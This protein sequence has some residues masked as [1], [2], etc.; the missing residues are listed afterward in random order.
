M[1]DMALDILEDH[2]DPRMR[3]LSNEL[4][5]RYFMSTRGIDTMELD[6][7]RKDLGLD[8]EF[9]DMY[10]INRLGTVVNTT[11]ENDRNLN[12]FDFGIRA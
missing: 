11:Y 9:A 3:E 12:F 8:P 6:R 4:V 1:Q 7:V 2:F 10:L 5:N